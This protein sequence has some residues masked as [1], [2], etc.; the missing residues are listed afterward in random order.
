MG[1]L[2]C[3]YKPS[4]GVLKEKSF[5]KICPFMIFCNLYDQAYIPS[6]Q[7]LMMSE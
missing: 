5:K 3:F 2:T 6:Q 7:L 4:D 1:L